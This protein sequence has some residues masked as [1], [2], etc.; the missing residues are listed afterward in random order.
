M[1]T[2]LQKNL[3]NFKI[4]SR[5]DNIIRELMKEYEKLGDNHPNKKE[6]KKCLVDELHLKFPTSANESMLDAWIQN[7]MK[8]ELEEKLEAFVSASFP[9]NTHIEFTPQSITI[10][11]P[12]EWKK[13]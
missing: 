8:N 13:L 11:V 10:K 1:V 2:R 5:R 12:E 3:N 4:M 9:S 7:E 6:L